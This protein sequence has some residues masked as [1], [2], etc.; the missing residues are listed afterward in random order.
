MRQRQPTRHCDNRDN[1]AARTAAR[2]FAAELFGSKPVQL[3]RRGQPKYAVR[4]ERAIGD[5]AGISDFDR[6]RGG[7]RKRLAAIE[8]PSCKTYFALSGDKK[9]RYTSSR[10]DAATGTTTTAIS[11]ENEV[12]TWRDPKTCGQILPGAAVS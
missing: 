9:A 12:V 3:F 7:E 4:Y 5:P 11:T 10:R 8:F 1:L 2:T 6:T